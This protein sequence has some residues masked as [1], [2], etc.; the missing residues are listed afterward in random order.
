MK[1]QQHEDGVVRR[2]FPNGVPD[3]VPVTPQKARQLVE[4]V[5]TLL[6]QRETRDSRA[7]QPTE[8]DRNFVH[9]F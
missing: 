6:S 9:S 1:K 2:L 4:Q 8:E 5:R 3:D 7:T